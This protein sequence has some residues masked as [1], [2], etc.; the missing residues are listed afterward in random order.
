M[1]KKE[2]NKYFGEEKEAL[3][4]KKRVIDRGLKKEPFVRTA[5][6]YL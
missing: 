1:S 5:L 3:R 6:F 2:T 4:K